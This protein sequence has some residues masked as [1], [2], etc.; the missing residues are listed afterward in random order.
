MCSSDLASIDLS[1]LTLGQNQ[2]GIRTLTPARGVV[3][4]NGTF[5]ISASGLSFA[6]RAL[7]LD[8]GESEPLVV[9]VETLPASDFRG[10]ID[11]KVGVGLLVGLVEQRWTVQGSGATCSIGPLRI[12]AGTGV[13]G[14]RRYDETTGAIT[15]VDPTP[16]APEVDPASPGCA[17]LARL[18]NDELALPMTT[19]TTTTTTTVAPSSTEPTTTLAPAP[20]TTADPVALAAMAP[21]VPSI[22]VS[23]TFDPPPSARSVRTT[24]TSPTT[25]A[26]TTPTTRA[27]SCARWRRATGSAAWRT[28]RW[29]PPW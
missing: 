16:E 26:P 1:L 25:V 7:R 9:V 5:T 22:V 15:V 24:T 27:R 10:R 13:A 14:S 2:V 28:R 20:P 23:V 17:D 4:G 29:P 12:G 11:P 8:V 18:A 19:T 21:P 6:P 3:A